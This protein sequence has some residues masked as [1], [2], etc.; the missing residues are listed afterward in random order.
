MHGYFLALMG[1]MENATDD[2]FQYNLL[3]QNPLANAEWENLQKSV[4]KEEIEQ[5]IMTWPSNK[6]PGPNRF[7][8]EFFKCS[9]DLL[10]PDLFEVISIVSSALHQTLA[11]LND[12][13][14]TLV[15]KKYDAM[16][17]TDFR[18]ISLVNSVQKIFF[19][20]LA[21]RLQQH[22]NQFLVQTH[23]GFTKRRS[24]F[25]GYHYAR[26]VIEA[27]TKQRQQIV[28]FKAD[29]HK[30]F[31]S[32]SWSFIIKCLRASG[33]TEKILNWIEFLVLQGS[34]RI[35]INYV[36]DKNIKL[37]RGVR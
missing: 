14:I 23:I 37:K 7:T 9:K 28:V 6:S 1:F 31:D 2:S 36:A 3:F 20:I 5:V 34:S 11:P 10:M 8:G 25:H 18:P 30:A 27:A 19:K 29:I 32:I 26:E 24:I 13:Y 16:K 33:F 12:S 17:P 4:T 21:T 15:T 22:M 35:I